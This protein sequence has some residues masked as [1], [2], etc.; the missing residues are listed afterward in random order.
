MAR[1]YAVVP[2]AGH[3]TRMGEPKLLLPL[4]GEPLIR[5]TIRAWQRSQVDQVVVVAR[6]GDNRLAA[7]VR[8]AGA[9][10]IIPAV[11]SPDMKAFI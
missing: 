7:V 1:S 2:A 3:S 8:E 9:A 11:P 5:H 10:L 4:A 6:P